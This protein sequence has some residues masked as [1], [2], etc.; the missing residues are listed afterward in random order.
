MTPLNATQGASHLHISLKSFC[1]MAAT[2][3][4][5]AA[6]I[7]PEGGK[8]WVT[9]AEALDAYLSREIAE[10]TARLSKIHKPQPVV[11]AISR[12]RAIPSLTSA[13][14]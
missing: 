13:N 7:G 12:S 3:T 8:E 14:G 1:Q 5:P 6:K 2:G 9:T 4:I 11:S 10:Q